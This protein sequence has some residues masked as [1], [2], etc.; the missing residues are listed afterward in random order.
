MNAKSVIFGMAIFGL[1]I[2]SPN[3]YANKETKK[4]PDL[5][6]ICKKECP[7]VKNNAEAHECVEDKAKG[8][9]GEAFK[10][11]KCWHENE[12]Y[13]RMAGG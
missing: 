8:E 10:K 5:V 11:T 13:E 4:L 12:K 6:K 3:S 2:V 9:G 7:D 1:V